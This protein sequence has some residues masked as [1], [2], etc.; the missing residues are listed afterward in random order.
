MD[1]AGSPQVKGPDIFNETLLSVIIKNPSL[2]KED[3]KDLPKEVHPFVKEICSK[4]E[5]DKEINF[6]SLLKSLERGEAMQLEFAYLRSQELW[7]DFPDNLL[8]EEFQSLIGKI[9]S[10]AITAQLT[11]M[12]F[13]I[14]EAERSQN[15]EKL[16]ALTTKFSKLTEELSHLHKEI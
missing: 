14:K 3:L 5:Q 6:N 10:R 1:S 7:K 12:E 4:V 16:E 8:K 15:K 11:D 9:K 2:F 13:D